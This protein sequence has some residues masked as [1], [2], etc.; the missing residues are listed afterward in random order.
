MSQKVSGS[1]PVSC[2]HGWQGALLQIWA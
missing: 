2:T 1:T